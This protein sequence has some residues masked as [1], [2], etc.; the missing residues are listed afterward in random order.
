M[1]EASIYVRHGGDG[2]AV[3]LLHGHP[4]TSATW[5]TVAPQLVPRG[6]T[7]VCPDLRGYGRSRGPAATS[8]HTVHS[9]RAVAGDM[10]KVM[11]WLGHGRFG[12]VGHDRGGY[13]AF[14]LALDYS[15]AV[16]RL[17]LLDCVA[18]S[19]HLSRITPEFATRWWHWFF[20][21]QPETPE[22]VINA[23][24]DSWYR[25]T[26]S[27]GPGELRRV[28]GLHPQSRRDSRH[29][30]GLP[31]R[32]DHRPTTRRGGSGRRAAPVDAAAGVVVA[33]RRSRGVL[34]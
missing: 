21:A 27:H 25:A 30:R 17:A 28:A 33:A 11:G 14:R 2:P 16:S 12:L 7:V 31:R 5:Y 4:R 8:D 29:A 9:K 26:R 24:P 15:D 23:D 10:V 1:G 34:W 22:R 20:F 18:I 6:F 19:D 13:V 32:P 3:L